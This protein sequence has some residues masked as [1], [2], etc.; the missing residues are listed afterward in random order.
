MGLTVLLPREC[1]FWMMWNICP[2][3]LEESAETSV[4]LTVLLREEIYFVRED[5]SS[6]V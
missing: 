4:Q 2:S 6:T 5:F 1:E 3:G